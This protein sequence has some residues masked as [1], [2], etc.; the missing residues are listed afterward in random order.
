MAVGV[1]LVEKIVEF[2]FAK[3]LVI[4]FAQGDAKVINRFGFEASEIIVA[5]ARVQEHL[6][7]QI[8]ITL[9]IIDV[10]SAHKH[11]HFLV[12]LRIKAGGQGVHGLDNLLVRQRPRT[13]S[14]QQ[15][16]RERRHTFFALRVSGSSDGKQ[17]AKV[18]DGRTA[19][20]QQCGRVGHA[21]FYR[22]GPGADENKC[23]NESTRMECAGKA[24]PTGGNTPLDPNR[25]EKA[26]LSYFPRAPKRRR[27]FIL[28]PHSSTTPSTV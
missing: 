3:F 7:N 22:E 10:R 4:P 26:P 27:H 18:N 24:T 11:G 16:R 19:R 28:P 17:D 13:S 6:T 25:T 15:R 9:E 23:E 5:K 14:G 1:M 8:V 20:L 21:R 2:F 12:D